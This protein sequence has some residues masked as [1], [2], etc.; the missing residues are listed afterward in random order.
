MPMIQLGKSDVTLKFQSTRPFPFSTAALLKPTLH[1][2]HILMEI[3]VFSASSMFVGVQIQSWLHLQ[4]CPGWKIKIQSMAM[5]LSLATTMLYQISPDRL[6]H[7][8]RRMLQRAFN[9]PSI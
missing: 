8:C 2:H 9:D 3:A 6:R 5:E 1:C 4:R 7:T